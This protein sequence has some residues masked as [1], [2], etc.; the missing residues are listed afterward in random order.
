MGVERRFGVGFAGV[1]GHEGS[2]GRPG[3]GEGAATSS[4]D[5]YVRRAPWEIGEPPVETCRERP[6]LSA[7]VGGRTREG[8]V[9]VALES[10]TDDDGVDA[11]KWCSAWAQGHPVKYALGG[12]EDMAKSYEVD[13]SQHWR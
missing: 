1:G 11:E 8:Q 5:G 13:E 12:V 6:A 4:G 7:E 10:D 2:S 3:P 9:A